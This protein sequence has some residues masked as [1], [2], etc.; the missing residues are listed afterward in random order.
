METGESF[1][2]ITHLFGL[3][4]DLCVGRSDNFI[5]F[6]IIS[7]AFF[8]FLNSKN[9]SARFKRQTSSFE[10]LGHTHTQKGFLDLSCLNQL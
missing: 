2:S 7:M 1:H 3:D 6:I 4:D 9:D 10:C 8:V 5:T